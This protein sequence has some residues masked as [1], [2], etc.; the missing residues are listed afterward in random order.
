MTAS[1]TVL[2]QADFV[3]LLFT[4]QKNGVKG[5]SIGHG[6]TGHPQ[7]CPVAV[8]CRRLAYLQRHG[9][10]SETPLSI[11]KKATKWQ[12]IIGEEITAPIRYS[13]QSAGPAIGF[14]EADISAR[15]L[16]AGGAMNLLMA[17]VDPYTI[18]LV[19]RWRSDTILRYLHTT[20]NGLTEGLSE[21]M[22]QHGAYTLIL[23]AH[24]GN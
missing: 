10:T 8:M 12:Q 23:P 11:F 19:G 18:R 1:N 17:R 22:F 21:N 2:S 3:S 16:R 15:S 7:G 4:T 24:S 9:A 20:E 14:T 6:R 13:V 5:E